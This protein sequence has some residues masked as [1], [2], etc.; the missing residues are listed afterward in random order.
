M[1]GK[2]E[3]R[4]EET[5]S[6]ILRAAGELFAKKG[7]DA[8]TMREIA[9]AANCSHT[10]I[11]IYFKDKEALLHMLSLP[12]VLKLKETM[13]HTLN[14]QALSPENKLKTVSLDVVRF[15]MDHRN[16]YT[17]F[18]AVR[19]GRVDEKEP[20]LLINKHRNELF[21]LLMHTLRQ[22]L[23]PLSDDQALT[24]SRIYFF[25]LLGIVGTYQYSEENYTQ[26]TNRLE[27]TFDEAFEVLLAGMKQRV[28]KGEGNQ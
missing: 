21:S 23:P 9:K 18:F 8:V 14:N 5:K 3:Q 13:E 26:L 20:K 12:P 7:Y 22:C 19:A 2:Q 17:I 11:Y 6:S 16:M 10:A 24:N 4:S 27:A 28:N 15:C 25:T 1:A